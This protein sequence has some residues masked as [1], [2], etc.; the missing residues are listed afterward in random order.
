M[1]AAGG[2]NFRN[3][4]KA[5]CVILNLPACNPG[6]FSWRYVRLSEILV[7]IILKYTK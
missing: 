6:H 3:L 4:A 5:S 2:I 7:W 1:S